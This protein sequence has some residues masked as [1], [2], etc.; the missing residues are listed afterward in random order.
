MSPAGQQ[1]QPTAAT[2]APRD[3]SPD[4][5]NPCEV[6]EATAEAIFP[7]GFADL[8]ELANANQGKYW[9]P[10]GRTDI[11]LRTQG[12]A[13][14]VD[15]QENGKWEWLCSGKARPDY[16]PKQSYSRISGFYSRK[17]VPKA[18][19]PAPRDPA[20][21]VGE[22]PSDQVLA[23]KAERATEKAATEDVTIHRPPVTKKPKK[24][25]TTTN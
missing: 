4:P 22:R 19:D 9:Y 16:K 10:A 8:H 23:A 15:K 5:V 20:Q 13:W 12:I 21:Y 6:T 11:R 18:G 3:V 2:A 24:E 17:P 25:T 14:C 1:Q 7:T